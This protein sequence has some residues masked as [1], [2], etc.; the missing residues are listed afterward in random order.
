MMGGHY[1]HLTLGASSAYQHLDSHG[2][3]APGG[4]YSRIVHG[5][6]AYAAADTLLD[7]YAQ[8]TAHWNTGPYDT[9][10]S[11]FAFTDNDDEEI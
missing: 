1:H 7:P 2:G 9:P 5:G 8:P 10:A 3:A 6:N 11:A 4:D